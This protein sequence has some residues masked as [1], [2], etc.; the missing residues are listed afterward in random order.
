M[1]QEKTSLVTWIVDILKKRQYKAT[2]DPI[3]DA[4]VHLLTDIISFHE[5][6][7]TSVLHAFF[8]LIRADAKEMTWLLNLIGEKL[9]HHV[10]P[11][12]HE[13]LVLGL[14]VYGNPFLGSKNGEDIIN[15]DQTSLIHIGNSL[16]QH[17]L[18]AH[19]SQTVESLTTIQK[20][21]LEWISDPSVLSTGN[22]LLQ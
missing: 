17:L 14:S 2:A 15:E 5:A 16:F 10:L 21:Y 19:P 13:Y 3:N 18:S 11:Q 1:V 22:F 4:L 12:I 7:G 20:R 8:E 6:T 9:P